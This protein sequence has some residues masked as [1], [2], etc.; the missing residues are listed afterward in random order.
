MVNIALIGSGIVGSGVIHIYKHNFQKL[1]ENAK[2]EIVLKTICDLD[3]NKCPH[4]LSSFK[5]SKDWKEVVADPD[6]QIVVELIGGEEPA[7]SIIK[8]ALQNHKSVVTANKLVLAKY[9]KELL[10]LAVANGVDILYEASVGGAIPIISPLKRTLVPNNIMG[11]YGIVNGTTNYI[12]TK[13][14]EKNA[15]YHEVLKDAQKLG[16]AEADPT[17]DVGGFDSQYKLAILSSVAFQAEINYQDILVEG[18]T[19]VSPN[20]ILYIREFDLVIKL[21]AIARMDN[22]QLELRVHPVAL[23][24]KH[25]LASVNDVYNA[26][27]V[28]GDAVGDIMFSGQ[29]AGGIPT[30]SSVW[31]DIL[32][33][34]NDTPYKTGRIQKIKIKAH[35]DIKSEYYFRFRVKDKPGVLAEISGV[36]AKYEISI[37]NAMQKGLG[38]GAELVIISHVIQEKYKNLAVGE[39]KNLSSVKK[40]SSV[41]RVGI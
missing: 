16:Y 8:A 37:K 14:H 39:I 38:D 3:F 9:G 29:G 28:V 15:R 2:K 20:D 21:V 40:V 19:D 4:D 10:E 1:R 6:I 26:I 12:L 41:I 23:N 24:R 17:S 32:D 35:D 27:Y 18:I 33:I 7:K 36:F 34:V 25:P 22:G 13:M 31:A 30:A 5:L 11:I